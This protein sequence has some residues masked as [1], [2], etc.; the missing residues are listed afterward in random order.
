[1][2]LL[3]LDSPL[4]GSVPQIQTHSVFF[5]VYNLQH[6]RQAIGTQNR[7]LQSEVFGILVF[8]HLRHCILT[9]CRRQFM[10]QNT[11]HDLVAQ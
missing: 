7:S 2:N 10:L 3:H 8:T 5:G 4:C 9:L 11:G 1:M 6:A